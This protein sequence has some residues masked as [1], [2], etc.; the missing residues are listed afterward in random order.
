MDKFSGLFIKANGEWQL[1]GQLDSDVDGK[2][3]L[4]REITDASGE[5][6]KGQ[7]KVKAE[8]ACIIHSTKGVLKRRN[9]A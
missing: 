7:K 1:H 5:I 2:I 9:F 6:G 3:K 8:Q 4:L